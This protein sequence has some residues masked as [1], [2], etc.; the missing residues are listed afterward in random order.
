MV[1]LENAAEGGAIRL[2]FM[3][4]G[5]TQH[6]STTRHPQPSSIHNTVLHT[7]NNISHLSTISPDGFQQTHGFQQSRTTTKEQ[8]S[9]R[10][11]SQ[12]AKK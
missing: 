4:N 8:I 9:S 11:H 7:H 3:V 10:A 12:L 6:H 1:Y 5:A 2:F